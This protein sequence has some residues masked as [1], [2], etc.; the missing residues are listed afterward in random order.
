[1]F[2]ELGRESSFVHLHQLLH[3]LLVLADV[4]EVGAHGLGGVLGSGVEVGGLDVFPLLTDPLEIRKEVL[5]AAGNLLL[6]GGGRLSEI[7]RTSGRWHLR[8]FA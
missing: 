4:L 7:D 6:F 2:A 1:M 8:H 5:E 3:L